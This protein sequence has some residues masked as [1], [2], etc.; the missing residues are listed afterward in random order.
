MIHFVF[1]FILPIGRWGLEVLHPHVQFYYL[2]FCHVVGWLFVICGDALILWGFLPLRYWCVSRDGT[3]PG[4]IIHSDTR[5]LFRL[6]GGVSSTASPCIGLSMTVV[7]FGVC[8]WSCTSSMSHSMFLSK[9]ATM[10]SSGQTSVCLYSTA[11]SPR[12]DWVAFGL[13]C[14]VRGWGKSFPSHTRIAISPR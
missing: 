14:A 3:A 10:E 12:G 13:A 4:S 11:G 6:L 2:I 7:G 5:H 1:N 9:P 8:D